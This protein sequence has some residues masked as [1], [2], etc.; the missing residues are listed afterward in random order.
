MESGVL[1]ADSDATHTAGPCNEI[2]RRI[3]ERPIGCKEIGHEDGSSGSLFHD[4]QAIGKL[5]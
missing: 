3:L 4:V 2:P 1:L 5:D